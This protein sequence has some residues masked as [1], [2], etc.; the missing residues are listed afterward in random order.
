LPR[1]AGDS[2]SRA[3]NGEVGLARDDRGVVMVVGVLFTFLWIGLAWSIFGIGNAIAYRENL[4]NAADASAFAAAVYD[5]RG[6]NLLASINIIMGVI[7]AILIFAHLVQLG[8]FIAAAA[9][10]AACIAVPYCG[11]SCGWDVCPDSC[12][13]VSDAN[14][15]VADVDTFVHDA[16]PLFHDVEVG[17]AVGWPWFASGKSTTLGA[18][19]YA[20]GVNLTSSFAFSQIPWNAD[21]ELNKLT[22]NFGD[23]GGSSSDSNTDNNRYGLPVSSDKYSNLCQVAFIDVTS[24]GGWIN[25]PGFISGI[26]N[27]AGD[28]FCD[29]GSDSHGVTTG[30]EVASSLALDCW[31][32][33]FGSPTPTLPMSSNAASGTR[34]NDDDISQSPMML[35]PPAKMGY[36]YFG[37]WST[38]IGNFTDV[39]TG[40]VQ[41][42]GQQA[43]SGNKIVADVPVD[44]PL[45]L[46]KSEF[47][48]DPMPGESS[49]DETKIDASSGW[50]IHNCMWNMRWR[51]RLRRYHF[52]P[53]ILGDL[54]AA[55]SLLM[56][57]NLQQAATG[58]VTKLING[59]SMTQIVQE[60]TGADTHVDSYTNPVAPGVYH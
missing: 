40:K 22:S 31:L 11:C 4:Q 36:D 7:L 33:G 44:T 42:A 8:V 14:S 2:L 24:L 37:V 57:A 25:L 34:V 12:S 15:V 39:T 26:L 56:T 41:I 6:M 45:G 59:E 18:H 52:F 38:A 29:A 13:A 49:D 9:A 47:Y 5:A 1:L 30:I 54:D 28:W 23:F 10:C 60:I 35:Y 16:L 55:A 17:I 50:P 21:Q 19:Y 43:Q 27:K 51:A 3:S 53:G 20:A 58:A 48:Y 32:F 46:A